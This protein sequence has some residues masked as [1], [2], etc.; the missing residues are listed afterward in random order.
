MAR[1][2]GMSLDPEPVLFVQALLYQLR[3]NTAI[4]DVEIRVGRLERE[5]VP[6]VILLENAG[7]LSDRSL[8]AFLPARVSFTTYGRSEDEA[9]LIYR[10]VHNLLHRRGPTRIE[11]VAMWRAFDE[12]GP[13]VREDPNTNWTARFGVMGIYMPDVALTPIGS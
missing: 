9:I 12:T 11:N 7:E 3:P 8:P 13:Q 5:D 6:P 10:V 1:G 2:S 4:G